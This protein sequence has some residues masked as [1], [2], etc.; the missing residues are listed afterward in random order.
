MMIFRLCGCFQK[1]MRL[2]MVRSNKRKSDDNPV[3]LWLNSK[4]YAKLNG[5]YAMPV[6][7]PIL[8]KTP[9]SIQK[10]Q[11]EAFCLNAKDGKKWILKKF[12]KAKTLDRSYLDKVTSILPKE[13]AFIAGTDREILNSSKHTKEPQYYYSPK[14]A[15]FINNTI[16]MPR[17]VG[18]DWSGVADDIRNGDINPSKSERVEIALDLARVIQSLEKAQCSHRDLSS[19][20]VFINT[21]TSKIYLIDFDSLYHPS[22]K[23]PKQTTCGTTGYIPRFTWLA[24]ELSSNISWCRFSDRFSMSLLIIEF[25]VMAKGVPL[26]SD[27]GIFDQEELRRGYGG[28]IRDISSELKSFWPSVHDLFHKTLNACSFGQCPSPLD[29]IKR[30][31][32]LS[33]NIRPPQLIAMPDFSKIAHKQSPISTKNI[34]APKLTEISVPDFSIV[35]RKVPKLS[36]ISEFGPILIL[37]SNPWK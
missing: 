31:E 7:H 11:A 3:T 32:F 25:L 27:G 21:S 12:Y 4:K 13:K 10:G 17:I 36:D 23:M 1:R 18:T 16:L 8:R 34:R 28:G 24:G 19:G 5:T 35:L 20:N 22:L 2:Q 9:L 30:L 26:T 6:E 15:E 14:L 37:P 33:A 29:W